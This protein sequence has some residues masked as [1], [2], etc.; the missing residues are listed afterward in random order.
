MRVAEEHRRERAQVDLT[1]L[2][3]EEAVEPL[4][5]HHAAHLRADDLERLARTPVEVAGERLAHQFEQQR[6]DGDV[7]GHVPGLAQH[8]VQHERVPE[9]AVEQAV[10]D[11][12]HHLVRRELEA[13]HHVLGVVVQLYAVAGN[14]VHVEARHERHAPQRPVEET[15]PHGQRRA[16]VLQ[17]VARHGQAPLV[18]LALLGLARLGGQAHLGRR[19]SLAPQALPF[20]EDHVPLCYG[21]QVFHRR[22]TS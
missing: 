2:L 14:A 1:P 11:V 13:G 22:F 17:Y 6:L 10:D 20:F 18:A 21:R 16:G 15:E 8:R 12:A 3:R 9:Y 4:G 5:R 19:D 7:A